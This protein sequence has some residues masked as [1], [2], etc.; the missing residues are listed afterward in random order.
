MKRMFFTSYH[1]YYLNFNYGKCT[2]GLNYPREYVAVYRQDN[3][4]AHFQCAGEINYSQAKQRVHDGVG[5]IS[6][7]F[8]TPG[9]K[10]MFA[11]SWRYL[12]SEQYLLALVQGNDVFIITVDELPMIIN[13]KDAAFANLPLP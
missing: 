13:E 6:S 2:V 12:T 10:E 3:R 11:P 8:G 9:Y 1:I 5:Y 7:F 4:M